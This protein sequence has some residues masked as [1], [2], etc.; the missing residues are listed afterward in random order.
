MWILA[1]RFHDIP[2]PQNPIE[3]RDKS[4][5]F[6]GR[7]YVVFLNT[8]H[9]YRRWKFKVRTHITA[10]IN[11]SMK[12]NVCILIEANVKVNTKRMSQ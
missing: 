10:G 1:P 4:D 5:I 3:F 11:S 6:L 2:M 12:R 9:D 8:L 7:Q